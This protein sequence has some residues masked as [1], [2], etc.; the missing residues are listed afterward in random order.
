MPGIVLGSGDRALSK[1]EEISALRWFSVR[2]GGVQ[3]INMK[4]RT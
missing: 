4:A 1:A 2:V 3:K